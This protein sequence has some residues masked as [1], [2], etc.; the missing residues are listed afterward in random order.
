MVS[1]QQHSESEQTS[2]SVKELNTEILKF[3]KAE[4]ESKLSQIEDPLV[5]V[6]RPEGSRCPHSLTDLEMFCKAERAD[7]AKLDVGC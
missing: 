3:S 6:K 5:H 4:P 7:I 2:N 1:C